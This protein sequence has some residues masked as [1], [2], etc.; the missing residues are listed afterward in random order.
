[1]NLHSWKDK[2]IYGCSICCPTKDENNTVPSATTAE[3]PAPLD[4][5]D[6]TY[7]PYSTSC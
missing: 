6:I 7:V 2:G 4:D 1:M 5:K 3:S